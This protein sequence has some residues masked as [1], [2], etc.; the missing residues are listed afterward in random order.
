MERIR[1]GL[2]DMLLSWKTEAS[3]AMAIAACIALGAMA[4]VLALVPGMFRRWS[5]TR[6]LRARLPQL[7]AEAESLR[8]ATTVQ[9]EVLP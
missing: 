8:A 6:T 5:E 2:A 1:E 4:T 7:E 3:L 9:S